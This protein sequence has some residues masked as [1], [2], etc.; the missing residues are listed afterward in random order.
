MVQRIKH[1][2]DL[3]KWFNLE[4]YNKA[5]DLDILGWCE[6]LSWRFGMLQMLSHPDEIWRIDAPCKKVI[7]EYRFQALELARETPIIDIKHDDLM[8]HFFH[9]G[10]LC[11]LRSG[12]PTYSFGVH[13]TTV[14]QHYGTENSMM[15]EKRTYARN[16]FAQIYDSEDWFGKSPKYKC[17]DWIDKP[18]DN[19]TNADRTLNLS[20][21]LFVPDKILLKQFKKLLLEIR[22][23]SLR[24]GISLEEKSRIDFDAWLKSGVLP[25]LDLHIWKKETGTK[26]PDRVMAD[27]IFPHG[28]GGEDTVRKT[29][30]KHAQYLMTRKFLEVLTAVATSE[31]MERNNT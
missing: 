24:Y 17:Q 25:Y 29:T 16:F 13:Q 5:A 26:F 19:F 30:V 7:N 20:V 12:E 31:I 27:A 1:V 18:I 3:P 23:T 22:H 6:Q 11:E 4:K 2:S 14:R 28:E 9:S 15:E 21:N 10:A 8:V